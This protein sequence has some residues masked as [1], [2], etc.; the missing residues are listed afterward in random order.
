MCE[1]R[2]SR[3]TRSLEYVEM[4][5]KRSPVFVLVCNI[6][7]KLHMQKLLRIDTYI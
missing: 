6:L 5:L 4:F 1:P 3:I 2:Q 7:Y